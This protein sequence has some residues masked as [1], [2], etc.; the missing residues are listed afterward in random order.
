MVKLSP[1]AVD[2]RR[3]IPAQDKENREKQVCRYFFIVALGDGCRA[4]RHHRSPL[5]KLGYDSDCAWSGIRHP[6][7]KDGL[8]EAAETRGGSLLSSKVPRKGR[9]PPAVD[10][11]GEHKTD[12]DRLVD[13]MRATG[14]RD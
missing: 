6:S 9:R 1:F 5:A 4:P 11:A 12:S 14:E 10:R 13:A 7:R 3:R 8:K 2:A